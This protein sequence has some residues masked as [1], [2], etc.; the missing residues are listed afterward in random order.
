M[1]THNVFL[2]EDNRADILLVREALAAHQVQHQ[3][4]VVRDGSAALEFVAHMGEPG[5]APCPDIILLDLNLPKVDGPAILTEF[6]K[7]P[8][9]VDTPVII[10]TS[11]DTPRDREQMGALGIAHYFRKPSDLDA[12]MS[13]GAVVG[14]LLRQKPPQPPDPA[15]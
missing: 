9:C 2:A 15:A 11:S 5:G 4:H 13:L 6:R 3:L 12:F 7:H 14:D 1:S 8:Q 10:I